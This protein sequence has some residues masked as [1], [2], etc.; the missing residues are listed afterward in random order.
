MGMPLK[1][2]LTPA[3]QR[4]K[5]DVFENL[6]L[7]KNGIRNEADLRFALANPILRLLCSYW[8]FTVCGEG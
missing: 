3:I 1:Y 2:S 6:S 4:C 8:N 7:L 5:A